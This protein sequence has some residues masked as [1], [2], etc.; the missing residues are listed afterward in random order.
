MNLEDD[1]PLQDYQD[2]TM[3]RFGT[4]SILWFNTKAHTLQIFQLSGRII[5][6]PQYPPLILDGS[7]PSLLNLTQL[8]LLGNGAY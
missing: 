2:P 5:S 7:G 8:I 3:Y 4:W 1:I 6:Y